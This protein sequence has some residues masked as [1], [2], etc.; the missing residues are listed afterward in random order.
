MCLN[1]LPVRITVGVHRR[2]Q[3]VPGRITVRKTDGFSVRE[4]SS[5]K[6]NGAGEAIPFCPTTRQVQS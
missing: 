2:A 6:G 1:G 5:P 3:T 4:R